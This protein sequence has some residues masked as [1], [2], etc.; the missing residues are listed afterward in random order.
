MS[1][2]FVSAKNLIT[3]S[4]AKIKDSDTRYQI[5]KLNNSIIDAE[6]GLRGYLLTGSVHFLSPYNRSVTETKLLLSQI[7]TRENNFS[8]FKPILIK[9][10][11]LISENFNRSESTLNVQ[12]TAGSY[13]PHLRASAD[14][15][16]IYMDGIST[17]INKLDAILQK[18]VEQISVNLALAIERLQLG[19]LFVLLLII[20]ILLFNYRRTISLFEEATSNQALANQLSYLA[21][22]DGLTHLD[23]RRSFEQHL[24]KSISQANRNQQKI[25]LL[26]MDLDGFKLINDQYGH[27]VGDLALINGV[28]KI[29]QVLRDS[30]FIARVGGDEFALVTQNFNDPSELLILANRII[31][32][33]KEPIVTSKGISIFMGISI[34]IAIYPDQVKN[35]EALISAADE[36]MYKAKATG[37]NHAVFYD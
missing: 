12:L 10:N 2:V 1:W 16:Q 7:K 15:S 14:A 13:S 3:L 32:A 27:D 37:K 9:L 17:E 31:E 30:D 6:T 22:H 11:K 24:K 19:S 4:D 28:A 23:N 26:Y 36:A 18:D 35:S 20:S 29:N 33:L 25:G 21:M 34:G 8:E 5:S